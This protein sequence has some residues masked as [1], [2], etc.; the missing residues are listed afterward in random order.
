MEK[1][2]DLFKDTKQSLDEKCII[3]SQTQKKLTTTE[4][5]LSMA[6]QECE[7]S[8]FIIEEKTNTES[9]LFQQAQELQKINA[10]ADMDCNSLHSKINRINEVTKKTSY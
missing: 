10:A 5:N 3:L 7:E 6:K 9:L 2:N 4:T 8:K 1:L